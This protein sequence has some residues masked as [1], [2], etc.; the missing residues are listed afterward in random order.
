[1]MSE[2]DYSGLYDDIMKNINDLP[3]IS[4]I[5]QQSKTVV[6]K[7]RGNWFVRLMR[8]LIPWKGDKAPEV[9][10]KIIFLIALIV[11]VSMLCIVVPYYIEPFFNAS[12][13]DDLR[14]KLKSDN[15]S[16]SSSVMN[17]KF[18]E[19]YAENN[20]LVGWIT[21]DGTNINYPVV[22]TDK[23]KGSDDYYL[24]TDF[25]HNYS[26]YGTIY[27]DRKN[28]LGY[29]TE[30]KNITLYGHNMK[31]DSTM[32]SQLL[33]YR[34]LDYYKQHPTFTFDTLYR[35]GK[36]KIFSV[37]ITNA[38]PNE[39]NGYVFDYR[40]TDFTSD[41]Q[42]LYWVNECKKRSVINTG[43]QVDKSDEILTLQTC[44]Y[45][46]NDARFIVIA[47][48]VRSGE[49]ETVNVSE[50]VNNPD[51]IY[52]QA[53]YDYL[54][55]KNPHPNEHPE[56]V[57]ETTKPTEAKTAAPATYATQGKTEERTVKRSTRHRNSDSN[58]Q[59]TTTH[60]QTAAATE[61]P[62]TTKAS[63]TTTEQVQSQTK[64]TQTKPIETKA[65]ETTEKS[66]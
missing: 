6:G 54:G 42:F 31:D 59:P 8:Y 53:W 60:K 52:P 38:D 22:R 45:E 35:D 40:K 56:T 7:R 49:S 58:T 41:E 21:V 44:T 1:M 27:A 46:F 5:E 4:E 29:M 2:K 28:N 32:F 17:P 37:M 9:I 36:W 20:D 63:E 30:S 13:T 39:D 25:K 19:L 64:D 15:S 55:I 61:A 43:V 47:R 12:L 14:G 33:H 11:F 51:P 24:R 65:E 26:R 66:D 34:D 18:A 23:M 48:R 57:G 62:T 10:R 16:Y 50:A 3:D